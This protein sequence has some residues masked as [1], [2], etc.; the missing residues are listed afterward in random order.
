MVNSSFCFKKGHIVFCFIYTFNRSSNL[1]SILLLKFVN[2][3]SDHSKG[4]TCLLNCN[5]VKHEWFSITP[6]LGSRIHDNCRMP[7][8][9]PQFP[10]SPPTDSQGIANN[11]YP[12]ENLT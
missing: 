9:E 4:C 1:P 3:Y 5:N 6:Q 10:G 8:N 12:F 11:H 7:L 2:S